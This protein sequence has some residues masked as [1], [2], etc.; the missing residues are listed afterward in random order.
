MWRLRHEHIEHNNKHTYQ[1][2]INNIPNEK[3]II[4]VW[5]T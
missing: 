5:R 1:I 2:S 3:Q 4:R